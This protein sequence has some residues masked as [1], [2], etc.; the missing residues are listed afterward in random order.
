MAKNKPDGQTG[1][2]WDCDNNHQWSS[3]PGPY[4]DSWHLEQLHEPTTGT[5]MKLDARSAWLVSGPDPAVCPLCALRMQ[6][7]KLR[8]SKIKS[9][10]LNRLKKEKVPRILA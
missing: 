2:F 10:S 8:R 3:Y 5:N 9:R 4:K 6:T 1:T 7:K